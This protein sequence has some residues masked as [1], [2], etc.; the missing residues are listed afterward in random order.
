M[1]VQTNNNSISY[2]GNGSTAHF[3]YDYLI[4]NASH[5]KVYFG[6]VL[7]TSGYVV[8]GVSSQTGGTVA[9]AVAPPSGTDITLIRDVPFLQLTDYQPYDAF[10]AESHERALDL[11]TMM[12]QQLKDE[13]G[14]TMQH[15]VGGNKWDAGGKEITNVGHGTSDSSAPNV[16]QVK[17]LV[18]ELA[19]P[20]SAAQLRAGLISSGGM[21]LVNDEHRRTFYLSDSKWGLDT[22][23]T[24]D[25]TTMLAL[26]L[27]NVPDDTV[28]DFGGMALRV[29]ASVAGIPASSANPAIDNAVPFN[30]SI[31]LN[32]KKRVKFRNGVVYAAN[33]G[34]SA[35]KMYFPS[36]ISFINCVDTEFESFTAEGKG[37]S[38]GSSDSAIAQTTNRRLEFCVTNGGHA[39][40]FG[41]CRGTKGDI[42]TRLCGSTAALYMSSCTGTKLGR[43]FANAASLGYNAICFDAWVGSLAETGFSDFL[44]LVVNPVCRKERLFRRED[45]VTPVGSSTYAGKGGI[46]TEDTG[47]QCY[48]LGGDISDM[49]ANGSNQRLGYAF[50][51]GSGSINKNIGARIRACQEILFTNAATT[52]L[53]TAMAENVDAVVG[54]TGILIDKQPFGSSYTK[55]TGNVVIDSSRTWPGSADV[56]LQQSSLVCSLKPTS[57]ANV[58]LDCV[59]PQE[60][61]I[62]N[63]I[64]N[65]AVA[66]YGLIQFLGGLYHFDGQLID[67]VGWGGSTAGSTA[68]IKCIGA[69]RF[70]DDSAITAIQAIKYTNK[71][72]DNVLTYINHDFSKAVIEGNSFRQLEG[73]NIQGSGL[74]KNIRLPSPRGKMY[75]VGSTRAY[76]KEFSVAGRVTCESVDGLSGSNTLVTFRLGC[77][78]ALANNA[79]I[80][81]GANMHQVIG[82][83]S[84]F[85][86]LPDSATSTY[87]DGVARQY[88]LAGNVTSLYTPGTTYSVVGA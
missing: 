88:V 64:S 62:T 18:A 79:R 83:N 68:G 42:T 8:G 57:A 61:I 12:A 36:T 81:N 16:G 50:G 67:S 37:E 33:A 44:A 7:Q 21:N 5:L 4:L 13:L 87:L 20:D 69:C 3:D 25:N 47:V 14:R 26:I 65:K 72:P 51:A 80:L 85:I 40:F 32:G 73:Y 59:C 31:C 76:D 6:D 23:A 11:L 70:V 27:Q 63:L 15:P 52:G 29:L 46:L 1:T 60:G 38:W 55:L 45:G 56:D 54:L 24:A 71:S 84:Q 30:Q 35:T 43:P 66:T 2:V 49:Y 22:S 41:R 48:S 39:A 10:P 77:N 28:L 75:F 74:V 17:Q 53:S 78:T 82:P 34:T 86:D 58:D 9:F 19:G